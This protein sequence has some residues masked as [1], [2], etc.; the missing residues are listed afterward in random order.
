MATWVSRYQNVKPSFTAKTNNDDDG[1]G[2]DNQNSKGG[3]HECS[4][5]RLVS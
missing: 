4:V 3:L 1:G 2:G 5:N